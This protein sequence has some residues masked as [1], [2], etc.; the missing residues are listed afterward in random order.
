[1]IPLNELDNDI[2]SIISSY[3]NNDPYILHKLILINNKKIN[4]FF[5]INIPMVMSSVEKMIFSEIND[6]IY[7]VEML[8][9]NNVLDD[10]DD[11]EDVN[12]TLIELLNTFQSLSY[13]TSEDIYIRN[14]KKYIKIKNINNE[15]LDEEIILSSKSK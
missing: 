15:D 12:N 10:N 4:N 5:N 14:I 3:I 13:K 8:I 9:N 11:D 1:M 7:R 2:I 6:K